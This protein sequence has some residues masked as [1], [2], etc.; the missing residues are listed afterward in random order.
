[1][2]FTER[3]FLK[4]YIENEI[5]KYIICF[6]FKKYKNYIIATLVFFFIVMVYKAGALAYQTFWISENYIEGIQTFF[7]Y[8]FSDF[9]VLLILIGL[10]RLGFKSKNI[11][12]KSWLILILWASSLLYL[13]DTVILFIFNT[14]SPVSEMW[15]LL[16]EALTYFAPTVVGG[17]AWALICFLFLIFVVSRDYFRAY[18]Q[19]FL[20]IPVILLMLALATQSVRLWDIPANIISTNARS[21]MEKE[22]LMT[23]EQSEAK[24]GGYKDFF[25]SVEWSWERLNLIIIFAESLSPI[26]SLAVGGKNNNLPNFD[27]IASSG[28]TFTNFIN[29]GFTSDT[30]HIALLEGIQPIWPRASYVSHRGYLESLPKF[31]NNQGYGTTFLSAVS[32]SFLNQRQYLKSLNFTEIV[33]EEAFSGKDTYVF[34][35]AADG[36]LYAKAEEIVISNEFLHKNK[37]FVL[38]MQTISF[39]KPYWTPQGNTEKDALKYADDE[40][41][42]F[43]KFL[44]ER[45]FFDNWNLIIVGDHR[46]MTEENK[47]EKESLGEMWKLRWLATIVGTGI[48]P[49]TINE[50]I[51]Q[52]TD[53]FYG[54]RKLISNGK[55][56]VSKLANSPWTMEENRE[57][58]FLKATNFYVAEKD[59]TGKYY[60]NTQDLL[61]NVETWIQAYLSAYFQFQADGESLQCNQKFIAHGGGAIS[62]FDYTNSREALTQAY[63]AGFRMFELDFMQTKDNR[64]VAVHDWKMYKQKIGW[65][66]EIDDTPLTLKEFLSGKIDGEFTPMDMVKV[67]QWFSEHQDAV[68]ITDKIEDPQRML[69]SFWFYDRMIMELFSREAVEEAIHLWIT[70][71]PSDNLVF[72]SDDVMKHIKDLWIQYLA[73]SR[74]NIAENKYFLQELK[75]LWI[76]TYAF[77]VNYDA[78][79]DE[80]YVRENEMNYLEWMYVDDIGIMQVCR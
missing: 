68:L 6:M 73:I 72:M 59:G 57:W 71:M 10:S 16:G 78:W 19:R 28:M 3:F 34:N 74:R 27:K 4:N 50:N 30:A 55:V 18:E 29:N 69:E 35:A 2:Y 45:S 7:S 36:D 9:I 52:Q 44:D 20:I 64:L 54:L 24:N 26:D 13:I 49:W 32:L 80:K 31:L 23:Y 37:P 41:W 51:T 42:N 14:N 21:L 53:I 62:W 77:H 12:I 47:W 5:A 66:G 75:N 43:Y 63:D 61:A 11:V 40:L 22:T 38:I 70:P 25:E 79:K 56:I 33:W 58:A 39:H 65:T 17:L 8:L 76:K 15:E 48:T 46:K 67:N 60:E 1:M